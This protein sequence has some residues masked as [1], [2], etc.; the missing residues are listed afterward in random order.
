VKIEQPLSEEPND[1]NTRW[2]KGYDE[3]AHPSSAQVPRSRRPRRFTPGLSALGLVA[4]IIQLV[5]FGAKLSHS[6]IA[7]YR[8]IAN[9]PREVRILSTRIFQYFELLQQ[10]AEVV[11]TSMLDG[12]MQ[13]LGERVIED[14]KCTL[15][16]VHLV[17][18]KF[19]NL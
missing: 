17:W 3:Q 9:A 19:R 11:K 8:S 1:D 10:A 13:I 6:A 7:I 14:S 2:H 4:S 15:E 12:Q 5:D 16:E 18:E